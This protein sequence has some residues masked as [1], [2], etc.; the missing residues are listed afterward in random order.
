MRG[1][2]SLDSLDAVVQPC[3][4]PLFGGTPP[5]RAQLLW[6]AARAEAGLQPLSGG[7][8]EHR[9]SFMQRFYRAAHGAHLFGRTGGGSSFAAAYVIQWKVANDM[10]RT[11][12]AAGGPMSTMAVDLE[13]DG[14]YQIDGA[15]RELVEYVENST[16][17]HALRFTFVRE[18]L[19]RFMAGVAETTWE[20]SL[21]RGCSKHHRNSCGR[22]TMAEEFVMALLDADE[23]RLRAKDLAS[24]AL[25]HVF[26]MGAH[27]PAHCMLDVFIRAKPSIPHLSSW[28]AL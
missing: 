25:E 24:A 14:A 15:S 18:P 1:W 6:Q 10:L 12:L 9:L 20:T 16:Q 26:P 4:T 28:G 8:L 2:C 19:E 17:Q 22:P 5:C 23:D 3:V 27:L 11:S 21:M 13:R 7:Q